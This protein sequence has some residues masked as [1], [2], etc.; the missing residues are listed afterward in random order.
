MPKISI[1]IPVY[2]AEGFI[3]ETIRSLLA[4]TLA[5]CEY[6]FVNDG[7][8]DNSL[9]LLEAYAQKDLRIRVVDQVNRGISMARN[10]GVAIARGEYIGFMDNDDYVKPDMYEVLYNLAIANDLDIVISKTILGRDGKYIIKDSIFP[11]DMVYDSPFIQQNII[12]SLLKS[13]DLFAVWNKLYKR[14]F[15][16]EHAVRFPNNRD[17]EEDSMFNFKAFNQAAKVIFTN[18]SG[19]YY[20]DVVINESKKIIE[21][22]YF[23]RAVERYLFDYK[24]ELGLV[25]NDKDVA[26][27]TAIRFIHRVFY[28]IFKC[29]LD[30]QLS[31]KVRYRY[32]KKMVTSP[33]VREVTRVYSK[34]TLEVKGYFE[35]VIF[36][37]IQKQ[38]FVKL[39]IAVRAL[40]LLYI[41]QLSELLRVINKTKTGKQNNA[42]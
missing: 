28:L 5:D 37:I 38:S 21:R 26:R 16:E 10:A 13:E 12:P 9:Q 2:N 30:K 7:S 32:I 42:A 36:H 29:A 17:I 35:Q 25:T 14:S 6:I 40:Q 20:R 15:I 11:P 31:K 1:I 4:Q 18:Y 33:A 41:P 27:L 3:D 23:S 24:K 19:Y 8:L 34:G 22:D 39:A